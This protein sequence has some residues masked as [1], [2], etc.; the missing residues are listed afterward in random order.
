MHFEGSYAFQPSPAV[1]PVERRA[2][3]EVEFDIGEAISFGEGKRAV[4]EHRNKTLVLDRKLPHLCD[5][6]LLFE[7]VRT[8]SRSYHFGA[9]WTQPCR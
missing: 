9:T 5:R 6:Y 7:H 2:E 1:N 4:H 3:V 8:F